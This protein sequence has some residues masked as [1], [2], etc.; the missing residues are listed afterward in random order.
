MKPASLEL[1]IKVTQLKTSKHETIDV[2]VIPGG[3]TPPVQPLDVSSNCPFKQ[4]MRHLWEH[5]MIHG[6]PGGRRRAPAK[7]ILVQW[8][9]KAL[10]ATPSAMFEYSY[11]KCR[12]SN[13]GTADIMFEDVYRC[14][15][16]W[17]AMPTT[18]N[19]TW[20]LGMT[21][22]CRYRQRSSTATM[23]VILKD[24]NYDMICMFDHSF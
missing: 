2:A 3:L 11:K 1:L 14:M 5:W 21:S 6:A 22:P 8:L 7:K 23:K 9:V 10:G 17:S 16:P 12:I 13:S 19:Q 24:F 15:R 20:I 4:Q 18:R